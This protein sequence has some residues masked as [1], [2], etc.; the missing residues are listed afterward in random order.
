[1][2]QKARQSCWLPHSAGCAGP[3]AFTPPWARSSAPCRLGGRAGCPRGGQNPPGR[4][5][6]R[7]FRTGWMPWI[8]PSDRLAGPCR[9]G[10][11]SCF[12]HLLVAALRRLGC[13]RRVP[14]SWC[15]GCSPAHGQAPSGWGPGAQGRS[16]FCK[17]TKIFLQSLTLPLIYSNSSLIR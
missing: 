6:R 14:S 5:C 17:V 8:R 7:T 4:R 1:M 2:R 13:R 11:S 10:Q 3:P 9:T 16:C 15:W 12:C